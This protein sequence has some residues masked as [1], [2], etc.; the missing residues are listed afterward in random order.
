MLQSFNLSLPFGI[1][2]AEGHQVADSI[3][4]LPS[5]LLQ[6]CAAFPP[7]SVGFLCSHHQCKTHGESEGLQH[8]TGYI[9]S[10]ILSLFVHLLIFHLLEQEMQSNA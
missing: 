3:E 6:E 2:I 9:I 7:P 4:P 5:H 10:P 8:I 1:R